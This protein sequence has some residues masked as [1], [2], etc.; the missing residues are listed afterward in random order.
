MTGMLRAVLRTVSAVVRY[1][2]RLESFSGEFGAILS[3]ELD[4]GS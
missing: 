1:A 4:S 2:G 3:R